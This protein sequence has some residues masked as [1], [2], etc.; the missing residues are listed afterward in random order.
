MSNKR[1]SVEWW[2]TVVVQFCVE[3]EPHGSTEA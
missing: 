2:R 1:M 3:G